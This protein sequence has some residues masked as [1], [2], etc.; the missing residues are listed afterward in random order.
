MFDLRDVVEDVGTVVE[1]HATTATEA[2][3][4]TTEA[5]LAV[6]KVERGEG[7]TCHTWSAGCPV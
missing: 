3:M 7:Y 2:V 5:V 4:E 6:P 1:A